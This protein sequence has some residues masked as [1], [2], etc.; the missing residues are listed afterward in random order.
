M[1]YTTEFG[2]C[3]K[4]D[5]PLSPELKEYFEKFFG[6]RHMKRDPNKLHKEDIKKS[7]HN[8]IGFPVGA[9]GE[10]YCD[11]DADN[12]GQDHTPDVVDYNNP[13]TNVPGLWCGWTFDEDGESLE[14]DGGE[15]FY[16][17]VEWMQYIINVFLVPAGYICNGK[18][19]WRGEDFNDM[20]V[21]EVKDNVVTT[22]DLS[23]E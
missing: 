23:F 6:I 3:V 13:P 21:I 12:C 15:K 16:D 5:K 10:F 2:G 11:P 17:Y 14:W 7:L 9:E 19:K 20:G 1:G 4:L 8:L 22:R 18:I